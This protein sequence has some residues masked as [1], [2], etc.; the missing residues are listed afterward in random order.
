[1][2]QQFH[3][4]VFIQI[5]KSRDFDTIFSIIA[6]R[7]KQ[8]MCPLAG[9]WI[10]KCAMYMEFYSILERK[11]SLTHATAQ[12]KLKCDPFLLLIMVKYTYS[13]SVLYLS[14]VMGFPCGSAGKKSACNVG[15]LGSPYSL[16]VGCNC[17][18]STFSG[19]DLGDRQG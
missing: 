10:R 4:W 18:W 16:L 13:K 15:D 2:F 3:F 6:T 1:M 19:R 7:W 14:L 17:N 9:E 5:I 11:D 12:L 8:Y